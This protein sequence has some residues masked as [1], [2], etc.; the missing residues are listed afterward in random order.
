M[1]RKNRH[2]KLLFMKS[3]RQFVKYFSRAHVACR[4]SIFDDVELINI[5]H[6]S[7]LYNEMFSNFF[8]IDF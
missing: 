8:K 5:I 4:I 3:S 2:Q 1:F 6:S 7:Q